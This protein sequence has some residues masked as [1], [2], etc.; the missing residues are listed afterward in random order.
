MQASIAK[1]FLLVV[2]ILGLVFACAKKGAG[3]SQNAV[4]ADGTVQISVT[5]DGFTPTPV[6]VKVGQPL[7]LVITRKTDDTCATEI[8]MSEYGIHADLPLGKPVTVEFTPK[9]T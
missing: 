1:R 3:A 6:H 2:L 5:K 9:K 8:V 4:A 7:K